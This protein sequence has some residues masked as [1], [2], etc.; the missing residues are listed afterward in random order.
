M[1]PKKKSAK[2]KKSTVP[3]PM[4]MSDKEWR[5]RDDARILADAK[6]ITADKTRLKAA[7]NAAKCMAEKA[8][9][10]AKAMSSIARKAD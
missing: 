1:A 7:A 6:V 3:S 5:A 2:P 8:K 4:A 9:E 10:E